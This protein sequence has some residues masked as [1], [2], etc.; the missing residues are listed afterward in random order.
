MNISV[1]FAEA[2]IADWVVADNTYCR[3][4]ATVRM[5]RADLFTLVVCGDVHAHVHI[6][7]TRLMK[8]V[9]NPHVTLRCCSPIFP[10]NSVI[11]LLSLSYCAAVGRSDCKLR[12][13]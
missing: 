7:P 9:T 13:Q 5:S 12:K 10:P 8:S 6:L 2:E 4:A 11:Q 3:N 1:F